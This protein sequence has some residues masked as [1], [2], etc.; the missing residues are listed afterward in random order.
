FAIQGLLSARLL[1]AALL[2]AATLMNASSL[3]FTISFFFLAITL[4]AAL[5][6]RLLSRRRGFG[7]LVR[8]I[9]FFHNTFLSFLD[10]SFALRAKTSPLSFESCS[11]HALDWKSYRRNVIIH[12]RRLE[13]GPLLGMWCGT[14]NRRGLIRAAFGPTARPQSSRRSRRVIGKS[15]PPLVSSRHQWR[16][17][18]LR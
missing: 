16:A 3:F 11:E 1:T 12:A 8:I 15:R 10:W 2:A 17:G 6:S 18:R 14:H 7:R 5:L 13:D 4:L 9:L